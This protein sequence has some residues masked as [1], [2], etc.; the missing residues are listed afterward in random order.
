MADNHN[1]RATIRD[2]LTRP[3]TATIDCIVTSAAMNTAYANWPEV[4]TI[5]IWEEFNLENI[6]SELGQILDESLTGTPLHPTG[7]PLPDGFQVDSQRNLYPLF[8]RNERV[9]QETIPHA[10]QRLNLHLDMQYRSDYTTQTH[11]NA[12]FPFNNGP[13]FFQHAIWLQ[14]QATLNILA[15]LGKTSKHWS[16]SE[17]RE[18]L[19][20]GN[21]LSRGL[22]A[23]LRQLAN[24]CLLGNIRH[25]YLQTDKE[26]VV[27]EFTFS[28]DRKFDVRFMPVMWS[29]TQGLTTDLALFTLCLLAMYVIFQRTLHPL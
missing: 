6:D 9:L 4:R 19:A 22:Q 3:K 17:V 5:T 8:E 25:G 16:G 12:K 28:L 24:I 13:P 10:R 26:L 1:G 21:G 15:G 7:F 29:V 14:H 2:L 18:G 11:A 23:P 20:N 27:C